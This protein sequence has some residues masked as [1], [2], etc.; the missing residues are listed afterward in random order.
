MK[1]LV[2]ANESRF[3]SKFK[4]ELLQQLILNYQQVIVVSDDKYNLLRNFSGEMTLYDIPTNNR[5]LN[6]F[7]FVR[8]IYRYNSIILKHK[9]D[10]I[11]SFTVKP[12]IIMGM[13]SRYKKIHQIQTITGLGSGYH[14]S[15]ILRLIIMLMYRM[16]THDYLVRFHENSSIKNVFEN[17][18]IRA[19][20]D[21]VINGSGVNLEKYL[22]LPKTNNHTTVF[23]FIGRV[24]KEKGIIDII[25]A[26][27]LLDEKG[28]DYKILIVG[29]ITNSPIKDLNI[30]NKI[31]IYGYTEDIM[32]VL[33]GT[34]CLIHPS[35]HEGMANAILEASASGRPS[36]VSNIPGCK[37]SVI[38]GITGYTFEVKNSHDLADKMIKFI[39]LEPSAKQNMGIE[40][41]AH[42]A[43]FFNR[44]DVNQEYIKAINNIINELTKR[45]VL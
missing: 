32:C 29:D 24:M 35:H 15:K 33:E 14:N 11:I 18:N 40:A 16:S 2:V 4:L 27:N 42:V 8:L 26:A 36:I 13:I 43:K 44:N 23:T 22:I 10:V 39:N 25:T 38:D 28:I 9:P 31:E 19:K 1:V 5:S 20:I 21:L 7:S 17:R 12:N 6:P 3:I 30:S 37:E 45:D 34:D 41:R